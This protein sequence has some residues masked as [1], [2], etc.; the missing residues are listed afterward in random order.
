MNNK[1]IALV[2]GANKGLGFETSRQLA[3][4]GVLV[5]MG[6]RNAGRGDAAA[7]KLKDAGLPAESIHLDVT[8]HEH[9][10]TA[11][12][13]INKR[14]GK[15][16]ILVNNAGMSHKEESLTGNSAGTISPRALREIFDA[17]FFGLVELTQKLL[18]LLKTSDSGR[19]VNV[20]S[21]LG[22]LAIQGKK[23]E[24]SEFKPFAYDASKTAVNAFTIHLAAALASTKVKVNSAHPGWVRTDMGGPQAPVMPEEGAKT[25][26]RLALLGPDGPTGKFF[27]GDEELPW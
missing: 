19:I 20:S 10:K 25:A 27:H 22:S 18:P 24:M 6:A 21:I 23:G 11:A 3:Q 8:N 14:F 15:L 13:E 1:K 7:K 4:Q 5:L 2:T 9:I 16:D 26:V 12:R 17:N